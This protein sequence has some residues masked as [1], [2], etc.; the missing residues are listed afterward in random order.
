MRSQI[1]TV[2]R[3]FRPI[4]GHLM[5]VSRRINIVLPTHRSRF[6]SV[7]VH[8]CKDDVSTL[9]RRRTL[10]GGKQEAA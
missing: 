8:L 1:G 9:V 7:D 5:S 4:L 3:E 2:A 6:G 10:Y